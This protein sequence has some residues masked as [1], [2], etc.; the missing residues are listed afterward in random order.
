MNEPSTTILDLPNELMLHI[1]KHLPSPDLLAFALV[2]R[3]WNACTISTI[4][5]TKRWREPDIAIAP[6]LKDHGSW[7]DDVLADAIMPHRRRLGQPPKHPRRLNDHKFGPWLRTSPGPSTGGR[8]LPHQYPLLWTPAPGLSR[9][10][11]LQLA[12]SPQHHREL[13]IW[14]QDIFHPCHRPN[15]RILPP[16]PLSHPQ[17]LVPS[18]RIPQWR[19]AHCRLAFRPHPPAPRATEASGYRSTRTQALRRTAPRHRRQMLEL[20]GA[21]AQARRANG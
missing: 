4:D 20:G 2:C 21:S 1:A 17:P 19:L 9:L 18:C 14:R 7:F 3:S 5:S 6:L 11:D 16:N 15:Y 8:F 12:S 13:R 10:H